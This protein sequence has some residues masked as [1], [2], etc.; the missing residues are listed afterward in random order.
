[1]DVG[2]V[3]KQFY[4]HCCLLSTLALMAVLSY[5]PRWLT[6]VF[7]WTILSRATF[8]CFSKNLL[9]ATTRSFSVTLPTILLLSSSFHL[10]AQ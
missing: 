1:M 8:R 4:R 2:F 9:G 10:P 3:V 6:F 7:V 5:R